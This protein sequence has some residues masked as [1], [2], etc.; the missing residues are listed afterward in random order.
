ML[1]PTFTLPNQNGDMISLEQYRGQKVVL[2]F[3]PKDSTPGCTT[4]ACDFRDAMPKLSGAV[5]IGISA[6]SQKKHQNFINKHELPFDLLVDADHE[7]SELYGVW[8]LKK[9]YGKEYY[10]IVRS[11]FLI[12][13]DGYIEQEWRSVKV[14]GHVDEVVAA[15]TS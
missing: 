10:G 7:V 9:N 4:E 3:Y 2:Y 14:N 12:N 13:E 11:T 15:V 1:A 6:D 5:V 8:Q